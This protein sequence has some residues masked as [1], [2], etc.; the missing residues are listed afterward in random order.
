MW[1]L[2]VRIPQ[3]NFPLGRKEITVSTFQMCILMLLNTITSFTLPDVRT[4]CG[5]LPEAELRR[6]VYSLCTPKLPILTRAIKGKGREN[7]DVFAVNDEFSSKFRRIKV[8]ML[9][10]VT[11]DHAVAGS[12]IPPD[13]EESRKI[14]VDAAIVRIMKTRKRLSHNDLIA[15]VTRQLS[16]RFNP[17]PAVSVYFRMLCLRLVSSFSCLIRHFLADNSLSSTASKG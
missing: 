8:P 13:V 4:H 10:S 1:F 14:T 9:K 17:T 16:H 6:Q 15:E 3:A 2:T 11:V 7:E 12:D 5:Q